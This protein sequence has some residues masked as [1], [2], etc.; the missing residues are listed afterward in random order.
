M[1]RVRARWNPPQSALAALRLLRVIHG[2]RVVAA[3]CQAAL[4]RLRTCPDFHHG[5]LALLVLLA[6]GVGACSGPDPA[7]LPPVAN[8]QRLELEGASR[9]RTRVV[10]SLAVDPAFESWRVAGDS[11]LVHVEG[12]GGAP[13]PALSFTGTGEV[14]VV[15]AGGFDAAR[16]NAAAVELVTPRNFQL[17]LTLRHTGQRSG[18]AAQSVRWDRSG[19]ESRVV[20]D[21]RSV[22]LQSGVFEELVLRKAPGAVDWTLLRVELL[23][24]PPERWLPDVEA[25]PELVRIGSE[26]RRAFGLA[27][28]RPVSASCAVPDGGR[29]C[30]SFGLPESE[31]RFARSPRLV[32]TL[33]TAGGEPTEIWSADVADD[34]RHVEIDLVPWAGADVE[35]GFELQGEGKQVFACALG[36]PLVYEP[37]EQPRT[38]ILVTSDTHR[39]DHV[40]TFGERV[41]V[42]TPTLDRLAET[43]IY[44]ADCFSSTNVTVPSHAA[45]LTGTHPRDTGV[46]DNNMSLTDKAE[47]LAERFRQA[48][49]VTLA[50][51]SVAHLSPEMT[52]L[53]QGFDRMSW[54]WPV[55]SQ[56]VADTALSRIEGWVGDAGGR[57]LFVW[58]HLFDPHRPYKPPEEYVRLYYP[59]SKDPFARKRRRKRNKF[60]VPPDKGFGGVTDI[61]WIRAHY[62]GEVS[63]VDHELERVLE[64][65]RLASDVVA[66]TADHGEVLGQ[67]GIYWNHYGVYTDTLH[68]PLFLR[69]P[70]SPQGLRV[71]RSVRQIDVG[72]TL[73][74]LAGLPVDGFPGRESL[75]RFGGGAGRGGPALRLRAALRARG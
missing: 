33:R 43:G 61:D 9:P 13:S 35:L 58:L 70:G 52:G 4:G 60:P 23:D 10:E 45:L 56:T 11:E 3:P 37:E 59:D 39:G 47:T 71:E 74:E 21:L 36:E 26:G 6:V 63:Y 57:P 1:A 48:G 5:L 28:G 31:Q 30:F 18:I 22:A 41:A 50:A 65:P 69:Y 8:I 38:V 55:K 25:E 29:L 19:L 68:V 7:E 2:I 20:F 17:G 54:P 12:A 51:T 44:F 24:V 15:I 67:H 72:R 34:W 16:F 27:S 32:V 40:G 42:Q 73:L 62:L 53:G 46:L 64:H 49:Y 75:A 66:V 14:S